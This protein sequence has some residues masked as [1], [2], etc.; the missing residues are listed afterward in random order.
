MVGL[1]WVEKKS[2]TWFIV[3]SW[4]AGRTSR[5]SSVCNACVTHGGG[6]GTLPTGCSKR[7]ARVHAKTRGRGPLSAVPERRASAGCV[8]GVVQCKSEALVRGGVCCR[9]IN[10]VL[11]GFEPGSLDSESRVL[12]ITP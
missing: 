1:A 2:C 8:V 12:T 7:R 10:E 11:P 4:A 5:R 3:S 9:G 6:H